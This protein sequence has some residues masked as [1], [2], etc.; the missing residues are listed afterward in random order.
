MV[1]ECVCGHH[2]SQPLVN[3]LVRCAAQCKHWRPSVF[4]TKQWWVSF[5]FDKLKRL[6]IRLRYLPSVGSHM[7]VANEKAEITMTFVASVMDGWL[8]PE[9]NSVLMDMCW[10][11][12]QVLLL[13]HDF[14]FS[15]LGSFFE[16]ICLSVQRCLT[17]CAV[18]NWSF[19]WMS[20]SDGNVK[21]CTLSVRREESAK[22]LYLQ[23]GYLWGK[24]QNKTL[25]LNR[26]KM[27]VY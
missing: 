15:W 10:S 20:Q 14:F 7:L 13:S 23:W 12:D 18:V 21:L 22:Y 6:I 5:C 17:N 25:S 24:L 16:S 1:R 2:N 11:T 3:C 19:A 26:A 9:L 27:S 4:F 8:R